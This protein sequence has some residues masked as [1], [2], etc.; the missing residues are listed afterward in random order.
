LG[1]DA[2][3]NLK[4]WRQKCA[5]RDGSN[6]SPDGFVFS[7]KGGG[8]ANAWWLDYQL[9]QTASRLFKEELVKNGDPESWHSHA[10]RHSFSTE[11]S[12]A[13]VKPE[14]RECMMGHLQGIAWVY[15]HPDLHE[16]DLEKE[17]A[18]VEPFVSLSQTEA[19]LK[20]EFEE[21][22]RNWII[23]IQDLKRQVARLAASTPRDGPSAQGS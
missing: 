1:R 19:V 6:L 14:V 11:C 4:L 18:K 23:E 22:R 8:G 16:E 21:E 2:V 7:G 9:K 20:G 10:L 15:Q 3:E 5:E 12:R 17:Y 13:G